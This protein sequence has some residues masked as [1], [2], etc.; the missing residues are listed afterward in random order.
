MKGWID[1]SK[2]EKIDDGWMTGVWKDGRKDEKTVWSVKMD[3]I[4]W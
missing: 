4:R 3:E 1:R 2:D